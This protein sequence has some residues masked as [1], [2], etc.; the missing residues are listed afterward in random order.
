MSD[1]PDRDVGTLA[2]LECAAVV[3]ETECP[4]RN[5]SRARQAFFRCQ[6]E[7]AAAAAAI[8]AVTPDSE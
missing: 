2:F 8:A 5:T 1:I 7:Q 3:P 4:G 6:P